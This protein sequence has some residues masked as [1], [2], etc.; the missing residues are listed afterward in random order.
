MT[1]MWERHRLG[2]DRETLAALAARSQQGLT[3]IPRYRPEPSEQGR[4]VFECGR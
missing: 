1:I 3:E 2:N 4:S